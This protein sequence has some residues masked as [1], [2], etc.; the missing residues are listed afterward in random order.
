MLL[1][2]GTAT[3][4]YVIETR[5]KLKKSNLGIMNFSH[6]IQLQKNYETAMKGHDIISIA[7][8]SDFGTKGNKSIREAYNLTIIYS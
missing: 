8:A 4:C 7:S 2:H 5:V 3:Q 1:T 6:R